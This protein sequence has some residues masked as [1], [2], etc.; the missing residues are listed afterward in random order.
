LTERAL[1]GVK[2]C[3]GCNP[4]Y[5]RGAAFE[6]IKARF[7]GELRFE[8]AEEGRRCD[9]LLYIA[10]CVNRCTAL[11]AYAS[12]K[13]NVVLWD[14]TKL[15]EVCAQIEVMQQISIKTIQMPR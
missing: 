12:A 5:D 11:D 2:F 13:G 10:G 7:A 8:Y 6:A 15:P 1:C 9:F 3:G 4:K 14:E